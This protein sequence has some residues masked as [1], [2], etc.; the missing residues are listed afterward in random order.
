MGVGIDPSIAQSLQDW[1]TG[2][3]VATNLY[4]TSQEFINGNVAPLYVDQP[5]NVSPP[6]YSDSYIYPVS[7]TN[8][9]G[10][11][12]DV[13]QGNYNL[14]VGGSGILLLAGAVILALLLL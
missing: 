11:A 12:S 10:G 2:V 1:N 4:G 9:A 3:A 7:Y 5:A 13:S 8:A 14:S 6:A